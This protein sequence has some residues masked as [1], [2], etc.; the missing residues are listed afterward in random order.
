MTASPAD[1]RALLC[2]RPIAHRGLWRPKGAPENSLAAFEAACAGG[3]G[4]ELD[5][6]LSADG[7][8]MV[9][10]DDDLW[11]MTGAVGRMIDRP[12]A[13]LC[14]LRLGR[15]RETIPT[16][17][18]TLACI[19][20]RSLLLVELKTPPGAEGPLETRVAELL[21]AYAGPVAVIGF[22]PAAH[23]WFAEHRPEVVRGLNLDRLDGAV[24]AI[25]EARP[26]FLAPS[27]RLLPL[28]PSLGVF[29]QV[30]WTV[31]TRLEAKALADKA[32][33]IIFEGFQP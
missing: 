9:F 29:R 16:L 13:D 7:E 1:L 22:N 23:A 18:Q 20:G 5:V 33:N 6:R 15:S 17:A 12:A 11:R 26:L 21:D 10:H 30:V 25:A 27:K 14:A 4:V 32:D 28:P 19:A 3:Y 8:A 31:R 2:G 24:A